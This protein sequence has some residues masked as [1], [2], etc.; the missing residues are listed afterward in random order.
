MIVVAKELIENLRAAR[1]RKV[2]AKRPL[3]ELG[4]YTENVRSG[5]E[6]KNT[7]ISAAR[8]LLNEE[9]IYVPPFSGRRVANK[10]FYD[11]IPEPNPNIIPLWKLSLRLT[12]NNGFVTLTD[13][14]RKNKV[15][16]WTSARQEQQNYRLGR[17]PNRILAM[18]VPALVRAAAAGAQFK[19][20]QFR[21]TFKYVTRVL[22]SIRRRGIPVW[23]LMFTHLNAHNGCRRRKQARK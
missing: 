13:L 5:K 1:K 14:Q 22:R 15:L 8:N 2:E 6:H 17:S 11:V 7:Q 23:H 10:N 4:R 19:Y 12:R 18:L 16:Y 21:G 9:A 20:V 3:D